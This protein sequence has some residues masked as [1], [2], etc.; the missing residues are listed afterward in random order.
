MVRRNSTT[1]LLNENVARYL[2]RMCCFANNILSQGQDVDQ[3]IQ[4]SENVGSILRESVFS[5]TPTSL[6]YICIVTV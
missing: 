2:K 3:T 6:T 1:S 5:K 4:I